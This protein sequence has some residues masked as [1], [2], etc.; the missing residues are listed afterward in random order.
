L[1][2]LRAIRYAKEVDG[3]G[4]IVANDIDPVAV[5]AIQRNV[6]FSGVPTSSSTG[7]SVTANKADAW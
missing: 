2:G 1:L 5:Q 6:K 4:N 3:I 7:A